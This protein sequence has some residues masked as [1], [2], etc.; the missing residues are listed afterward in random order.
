M[1]DA[2]QPTATRIVFFGNERLATATPTD[3]P[4]L[5][6][7]IAAGYEIAAVVSH[8]S[9]SRSR[10]TRQLEIATVAAE[11]DIPLLLPE[12]PA[13]ILEQIRSYQADIG[14]LVA[15]GKI[16]S[17][18]VID[19]FPHGIINIHPSL[20]P[21]H[22]GPTPIESVI[23]DG[24]SETGV[25]VM[26]LVWAMDAG[27][28]YG[29]RRLELDATETKHDLAARLLAMGGELVVEL[30]PAILDGT[31]KPVAQDDGSA[32]YD[33]LIQKDDGILDF[34]KPAVRLE[35][36][37]RAYQDWPKSRTTLLDKEVIIT[38]GHVLPPATD[39]ETASIAPPPGTIWRQDAELGICTGDGILVIDRLKPSGKN[40][41]SASSF[42]A[43]YVR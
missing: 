14:V 3:A 2:R 7:L 35:R 41:M 15:Y 40:E 43:G 5:R 30:L 29:Q 1:A 28:V 8:Q 6:A 24:A 22:R 25:S 13:E 18:S 12:K 36:E 42:L 32:T 34:T 33:N 27:P 16:V 19:V 20:L 38:A 9:E 21:L 11:H 17:Q 4:T 26:Q 31:S 39:P 10:D 37:I 23:L